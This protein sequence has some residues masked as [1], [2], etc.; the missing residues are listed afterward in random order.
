MVLLNLVFLL[1]LNINVQADAIDC[2]DALTSFKTRLQYQHVQSASVDVQQFNIRIA[3]EQ[4]IASQSGWDETQRLANFLAFIEQHNLS[5]FDIKTVLE[6]V[7]HQVLN[8]EFK[9]WRKN[10]LELKSKFSKVTGLL[11]PNQIQFRARPWATVADLTQDVLLWNMM[12]ARV[13]LSR[14]TR[15]VSNPISSLKIYQQDSKNIFQEFAKLM[16]KLYRDRMMEGCNFNIEKDLQK[17]KIEASRGQ[18]ACSVSSSSCGYFAKWF[19]QN[20][21]RLMTTSALACTVAGVFAFTEQDIDDM[22]QFSSLY[23]DVINQDLEAAEKKTGISI[24]TPTQETR[25]MVF[26]KEQQ[27]RLAYIKQLE[28]KANRTEDEEKELFVKKGTAEG[29]KKSR[30]ECQ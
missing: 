13:D 20:S 25:C 5:L 29:M 9:F 15:T 3:A 10:R 12:I 18:E 1:L 11:T 27:K 19:W 17:L 22:M 21:M 7:P 2:T 24:K 30:P 6:K 28:S 14:W 23:V 16:Q 8:I 4:L 26:N